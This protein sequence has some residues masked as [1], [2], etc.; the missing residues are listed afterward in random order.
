MSVAAP[1]S[2]LVLR[3]CVR[4]NLRHLQRSLKS[5]DLVHLWDKLD[6]ILR[7]TVARIRGLP[8]PTDK[9]D[10]THISADQDGRPGHPVLKDGRTPRLPRSAIGGGPHPSPIL[11]PEALP[12][13]T[14]SPPNS[15]DARR[16]LPGTRRRCW[17]H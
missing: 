3:V 17:A 7:D 1:P 8:R 12:A 2:L 5:D 6:A 9:L 11:T 4:Q 15:N 16:S 14:N 10:A 13:S